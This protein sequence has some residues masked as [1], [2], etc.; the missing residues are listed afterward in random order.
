MAEPEEQAGA[1]AA[2]SV[3]A[4]RVRNRRCQVRRSFLWRQD[5]TPSPLAQVLRSGRGSSV[6]LKLLLSLLWVGAAPPHD[7]SIPAR[8]WAEL[9]GVS[10]PTGAGARQIRSGFGW[11]SRAGFLTI[12][13]SSSGRPTTVRLRDESLSGEDYTVPGAALTAAGDEPG[14]R[15]HHYLTLPSSLWS[16]GWI[17]TLDGPSIAMLLVLLDAQGGQPEG[18]ELWFSPRVASERYGLSEGTWTTGTKELEA[19]GVII[20]G[21]QPVSREGLDYR[22]TRKTYEL[23]QDRFGSPP[24]ALPRSRTYRRSK[25]ATANRSDGSLPEG[26]SQPWS[27]QDLHRLVTT[28]GATVQRLRAVMDALANTPDRLVPTGELAERTGLTTAEVRS[29]WTNLDRVL[30]RQFG[31][32]SSPVQKRWGP[33]VGLPLAQTHYAVSTEQARRWKRVRGRVSKT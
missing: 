23:R 14:R 17:A 32:V 20:V 31:E 21:T 5:D 11:L 27:Q 30:R 8:F 22:R 13:E 29:T 19:H 4:S 16:N 18:T 10:D 2:G 24:S 28:P 12:L 7:I 25:E 6:R 26:D 33:D 9:L 15:R 1:S 3:L